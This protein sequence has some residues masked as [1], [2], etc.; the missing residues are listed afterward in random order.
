MLLA[1]SACLLRWAT[2]ALLILRVGSLDVPEPLLRELPPGIVVQ[3]SVEV[4]VDRAIDQLGDS[5]SRRS[6]QSECEQ[7]R[8]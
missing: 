4:P 7:L 6:A 8:G 1:F 5:G 2:A 3:N